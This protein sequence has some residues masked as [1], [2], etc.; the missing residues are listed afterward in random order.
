[1]SNGRTHG[2]HDLA[3]RKVHRLPKRLLFKKLPHLRGERR[4]LRWQFHR[5]RNAP[6]VVPDHF[7][8]RLRLGNRVVSLDFLKQRD[9][10]VALIPEGLIVRVLPRHR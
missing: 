4:E 9:Y 8:R 3:I 5:L 2:F 7:L 6:G 10:V 1:M